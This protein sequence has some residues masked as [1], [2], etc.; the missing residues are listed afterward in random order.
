[1]ITSTNQP[2]HPDGPTGYTLIA[3]AW[4]LLAG[5]ISSGFVSYLFYRHQRHKDEKNQRDL[6]VF[7]Y[8]LWKQGVHATDVTERIERK[9]DS[10]TTGPDSPQK[11]V[12]LDTEY[13]HASHVLRNAF[14]KKDKEKY[15]EA[16]LTYKE[17]ADARAETAITQQTFTVLKPDGKITVEQI[18]QAHAQMFPEGYAWAGTL[19]EQM[20]AIVGN[21]QAGGRM[22]NPSL[23]SYTVQLVPPKEVPDRMTAL[24]KRWNDNVLHLQ[25][26]D[27]KALSKE[28]A[29]FHHDFL[30][31][32]PFLDGNGR[33][34]RIILN[35]QASF[36][37]KKSVTFA[38]DK[39]QYY[40]TLHLADMRE[41][42][43]LAE[44]IHRQLQ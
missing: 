43:Q 18:R 3:L 34:S 12:A 31:I 15:F 13:E 23:S 40:Q 36:F 10:I 25:G 39:K 19:R 33:I 42:D 11:L 44:M 35:E 41:S 37:L 5:I 26:D 32:H 14:K 21:F 29:H 27:L 20:V 24:I 8:T 4:A 16:A 9:I 22:I 28:L 6:F 7:L 38:F 17:I 30:L 1:M 2:P